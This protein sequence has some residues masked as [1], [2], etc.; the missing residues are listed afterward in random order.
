MTTE[1]HVLTERAAALTREGNLTGARDCC[2]AALEQDPG[3]L[4]TY[5]SLGQVSHLM[6]NQNLAVRCYLAAMH[7]QAAAVE[8]QLREQT[9]S[10]QLQSLL[11][12][13]PAE[14][15]EELPRTSAFIVFADPHLPRHAAHAL[16]DLS[17]D[18]MRQ[19]ED[20]APYA[21]AYRAQLN[22]NGTHEQVL[23]R[24]GLT[25]ND[26]IRK[27]KDWYI[28]IGRQFFLD[29]LKWDRAESAEVLRI[30]FPS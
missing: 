2:M 4:A 15:L 5:V 21:D 7:L 25:V 17:R 13:F 23:A 14:L 8:R 12:A 19:Q 18:T 24:N 30:Y 10:V 27:D 22:G 16:A 1:V 26:Q 28:P 9:L 11:A 3:R 20:L 29:Q 6:S